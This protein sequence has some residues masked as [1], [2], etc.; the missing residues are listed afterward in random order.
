LVFK[1]VKKAQE[2]LAEDLTI[3]DM[4][5]IV[6]FC[7]YFLIVSG[8]SKPHIKAISE[9]IEE[10]LDRDRIKT[11]ASVS[12]QVES[13]WIVLDYLSVIIHIFYKPM[14]EFYSLEHLWQD[15]RHVRIPKLL[16]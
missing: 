15:A 16:K 2:K 5:K 3:L 12:A 11:L 13:G 4:R 7:D 8:S 6:N 1:I 10:E 14:R 9:A